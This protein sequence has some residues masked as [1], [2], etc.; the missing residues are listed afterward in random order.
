MNTLTVENEQILDVLKRHRVPLQKW[1]TG[2]NRSLEDFLRYANKDQFFLRDGDNCDLIVEVHAAI[3][4]VIY[5]LKKKWIE[6][7]EDRQVSPDGAV[8]RREN[9]NGIAETLKRGEAPRDGAMRG[10]DE[11]LNF[12]NPALYQLSEC[13]GIE[14]RDPV[15]SEKWPGIYA[16]YNRHIFECTIGKKLFR[17]DGYRERE[18]DG[19]EI[20]F[21]W[22]PRRQ[23]L[24]PL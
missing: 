15:P 19:R 7:Y 17:Q 13:L 18:T 22:R 24:L 8:L 5:Q 1:G 9:F 21:A 4:V 10:L 20:F 11:E 14:R 16:Q 3:V 12:C 6:L 2:K 23:L